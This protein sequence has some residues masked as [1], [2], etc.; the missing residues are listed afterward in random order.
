MKQLLVQPRTAAEK[1]LTK[2]PRLAR[3]NL[4][5]LLMIFLVALAL[6]LIA[7]DVPINSDEA[8]WMYRGGIFVRRLFEGDLAETYL[9]H[10]PGVTNMWMIGSSL[11]VNCAWH[12]L[13]PQ[14]WGIDQPASVGA[15][16]S[17][18]SFPIGLWILPRILQAGVTAGCMVA[19]Y[20]LV[21]RLLGRS[22][23]LTAIGLL[24]LEPFFLAYQ[25][26]L[27]TDALQT[28]FG[29]I[30]LLAML[31]Y[32]K[33]PLSRPEDRRRPRKWLFL[34]GGLMGLS[35]MAKIPSIF[36][37]PAVLTCLVAVELSGSEL[38]RE[39]SSRGWRR[40]GLDFGLWLL[41][42]SGT[43]FLIWPA[44]WVAPIG[45]AT[46]LL[47]GLREEAER[48]ALFYLGQITDAI[49]P[50]FYPAVLLYRLSPVLLLGIAIWAVMAVKNRRQTRQDLLPLLLVSST[51]WV[52]GLL[53][54]SDSKIDRYINLV[55]P[56]LAIL[57]AIGWVRLWSELAK[58][59]NRRQPQRI[60]AA[61]IA[62][63]LIFQS[64]VL[65]AYQPYYL[66]YFNPITQLIYPADRM[67]MIGQGEGLGLAARWLNQSPEAEDML[68]AAWYRRAFRPYFIGS[69]VNIPKV[70]GPNPPEW[71][72]A[73]RV[74][75]YINQYQR[76]LPEGAM[77]DYFSAQPLLYKVRFHGLDYVK[78]YPG[79]V[80]TPGDLAAISI[81]QSIDMGDGIQ[82]YGH[83]MTQL[84]SDQTLQVTTYWKFSKALPAGSTLELSLKNSTDETRVT[85][86]R[87]LGGY[88]AME[89]LPQ[90]TPLRDSQT[91][92][93]QD[94]S[95]GK[96]A[97]TAIWQ[98][99]S[100]QRLEV[101]L[102]SVDIGSGAS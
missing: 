79:P 100:A 40:Q 47:A 22:I 45:T 88:L 93:L 82:F 27:T 97:L 32:L 8:L 77:L 63:V 68:V 102:G 15:C 29:T 58:A 70:T 55:I 86:E 6:R 38:P 49:G 44:L 30:G 36:F 85:A 2:S 23:A 64:V 60:L 3:E 66:T 1:L 33:Q 72:S 12:R 34:S 92:P 37:I 84:D 5:T 20:E 35:V 98:T 28:D 61:G 89:D 52:L 41:T 17:Q 50:S 87:L 16:L 26:Y 54:L 21:R 101:A 10:H 18:V 67:F 83:D 31:V 51:V 59:V 39:F 14:F 76:R 42:I 99:P 62:G 65:V 56:L 57:A 24:M 13:H 95:P 43:A 94:L 73:N 11:L 53:S 4:S 19:I 78:I 48:G 25:R 71:L 75:L 91:I 69:S 74:I 81:P 46:K 9:R 80:A 90:D 7:V 96:Y